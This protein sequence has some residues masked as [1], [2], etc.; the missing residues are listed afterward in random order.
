MI[1]SAYDNGN[2]GY[3][4]SAFEGLHIVAKFF[5]S[6]APDGDIITISRTLGKFSVVDKAFQGEVQEKDIWVCRIVREVRPGK[7][8]GAF[9]LMPLERVQD[10][11]AKIRKLIPG[12]Y[13]VEPKDGAV[14]LTPNANKREFWVISIATR[15]IFSSKYYAV[16]VPIE[17][18]GPGETNASTVQE[19]QAHN[20]SDTDF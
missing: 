20:V 13:D 18:N 17:Y 8:Q 9:I 7:N 11:T 12:F 10:P 16:V 3:Y 14:V 6:K 4:K 1:K 2:G 15:Q 5:R 19:D